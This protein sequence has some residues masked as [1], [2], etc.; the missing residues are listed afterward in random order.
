MPWLPSLLAGGVTGVDLTHREQRAPAAAISL[1]SLTSRSHH[2]PQQHYLN[3]FVYLNALHAN[4]VVAISAGRRAPA[5][6]ISAGT[7]QGAE[8][9]PFDIMGT[10]LPGRTS[11]RLWR[12]FQKQHFHFHFH[13]HFYAEKHS[14]SNTVKDYSRL[15]PFP[16]LY[17][18]GYYS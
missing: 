2:Q 9:C 17:H 13:F 16:F 18:M 1:P 11:S 14:N 4:A 6:A 8:A 15:L 7:D 10:G 5:A 3:M 12:H